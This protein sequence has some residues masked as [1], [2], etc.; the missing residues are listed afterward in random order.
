MQPFAYARP[1]TLA[2]AFAL[3]D[4]HGPDACLL[5]GGTDVVVGLRNR[6]LRPEMVIDLKQVAELQPAISEEGS[7]LTITAT[8]ALAGIDEDQ[9]I[10]ARFPALIEAAAT[11]GS[12]Q[13]R[14]RATL[15]GNICHASPAADT[16][17]ALLAYGARVNVASARGTRRVD[18][19]EFFVGPGKTVLQ[20]GELVTAIDLPIAAER[21]GAAFARITRRRG[22]DLATI[23]ICC[24]VESAG[25]TVLAYGA[26]GPRPFVVADESGLLAD[27]AARDGAKDE[28]LRQLLT[29]ASPISDVRG[30]REYREAMLLVMSRRALRAS[31][32]RLR[33]A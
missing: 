5:A 19:D 2:D 28:V 1:A 16:A 10:H 18:L 20:R 31:L 8:T 23:S 6:T 11:V 22:V 33:A 25:R 15:T 4:E 3:L 9:R 13:I 29:K 14:N 27:P 12:A 21:R 30:S 7:W 24:V 17:P 26:V 32:E